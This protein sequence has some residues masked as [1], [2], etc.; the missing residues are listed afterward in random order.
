[1]VSVNVNF[2]GARAGVFD[3]RHAVIVRIVVVRRAGEEPQYDL[4]PLVGLPTL[5]KDSNRGRVFLV[6]TDSAVNAERQHGDS[7]E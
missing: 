6:I 4:G 3:Q 1:M 5:I 2:G 7:N